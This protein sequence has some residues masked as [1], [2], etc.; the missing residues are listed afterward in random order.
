MS[1]YGSG[2]STGGTASGDGRTTQVGLQS[3]LSPKDR[4]ILCDTVCNCKRIGVASVDGKIQRQRCVMQRLNYQ[5]MV[6]QV[7]TGQRT[8]YR[9]E[10]AYDM[11]PDVPTPIMS[12]QDPL[13]PHPLLP[14]WVNKYWPGGYAEYK[15]LAGQGLIRRPDV[16]VVN[17][18]DQ[19]PVQSNIK[20]CVEMKFP[21]DDFSREQ[22]TDYIRIAGGPNKFER[23][24]PAEC[25]C[26]KE[27]EDTETSKSSQS[28][29]SK[30]SDLED[31][32]GGGSSP[33]MGGGPPP[34]PPMP[35]L[36][37]FP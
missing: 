1:G 14:N 26:G 34:L 33:S 30:Q 16:I 23:I 35:P 15:K 18:P 32:F 2:Y 8:V 12:S 31:L 21:P 4:A 27:K 29:A 19:P 5:D 28:K 6:S 22:R 3:G 17:D 36:P 20:M 11:R 10:I 9:P 24:G 37:V 7:T 25:K 13:K